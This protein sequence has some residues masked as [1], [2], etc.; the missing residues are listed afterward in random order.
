MIYKYFEGH[1]NHTTTYFTIQLIKL[2]RYTP[3]KKEYRQEKA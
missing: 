1:F 2:Q 3:L